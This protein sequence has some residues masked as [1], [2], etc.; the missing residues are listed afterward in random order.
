VGIYFNKPV[1][2]FYCFFTGL[3]KDDLDTDEIIT[4]LEIEEDT[5]T[6]MRV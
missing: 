2:S 4:L 6:V 5:N 1:T 3:V